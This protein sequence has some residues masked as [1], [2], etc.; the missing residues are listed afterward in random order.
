M[1]LSD[2][3]QHGKNWPKKLLEGC[4]EEIERGRSAR[5]MLFLRMGAAHHERNKGN[6]VCIFQLRDLSMDSQ[7]FKS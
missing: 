5:L 4:V 3:S 7:G 1:R 2:D 6:G